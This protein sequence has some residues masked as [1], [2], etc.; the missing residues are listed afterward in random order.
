MIECVVAAGLKRSLEAAR[1]GYLLRIVCFSWCGRASKVAL[2]RVCRVSAVV[3]EGVRE[4]Y[5]EEGMVGV[6]S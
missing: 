1:G 6:C 5:A 3:W 2:N 4:A